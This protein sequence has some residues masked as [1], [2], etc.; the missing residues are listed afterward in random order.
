MRR[1]KNREIN[2]FSVSFLD[3]LA[4]TIGGLA[5]LLIFGVLMI[6]GI[7]SSSPPMVMTETLPD[8]YH[9]RGYLTWLAAREGMGKFFWSV[10]EGEL[11]PGLQLDEV[12]GK[13]SGVIELT[14]ADAGNP[15]P[16][17]F[18]FV[19]NCDAKSEDRVLREQ[20]RFALTV[21]RQ[22]PINSIPLRIVTEPGLP[23]AYRQKAYPLVFAAEGGQAPYAWSWS[24]QIPAGLSLTDE[25]Q[26]TGTPAA[27]GQFALNVT[28]TTP[29]GER[30]SKTVELT[31]SENYPP[32]P[33]IPPLKVLTRRIPAAVAEKDYEVQIAAHGGVPPYQWTVA[34]GQPGWLQAGAG[35]S[36][37]AGKPALADVGESSVV[38]QVTDSQNGSAR[39]DP[40]RLEV[41]PP[42][43]DQPPPLRI[44]TKALP[45]ARVGQQYSLAVAVEGGFPPYQWAAGDL[46]QESGL[47][48]S[49]GDGSLSGN[50]T[51]QGG[52]PIPISVS[53]R[54][55][56][57]TTA[58]LSLNVRPAP[59]P[60]RIL[61]A[62]VPGGR[63]GQS[64]AL[65]LSATGGYAPYEWR[66]AG[67]ELPPG[68]SLDDKTGR[69]SGTPVK[70]G[71]WNASLTVADAEQQPAAEAAAVKFEIVTE[72]G[73]RALLI[74]TRSLP[75][76]LEGAT[77]DLALACEGGAAPYNW[78]AKGD[79]PAG[80]KIEGARIIGTPE[81]EW[82]QMVKLSVAD[83]SGQTAE[84][85]F[86]LRV[87]DVMPFWLGLLLGILAAVALVVA[88]WLARI[89]RRARSQPLV[90]LS[91]TIPN[92]R[93][94]FDYSVQL[95]A[96]GG[97]PPY[98]WRVV[99]G[100][101]PKG[102]TL[103]PEGKLSGCPF[104]GV[105]VS[106]VLDLPFTV[107]LEDQK[108]SKARQR[109]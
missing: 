15:N 33:P 13:L 102:L 73:V 11:P 34:S 62:D 49:S 7:L 47:A 54:A 93:V 32:P 77:T 109:L 4:N 28:V 80:L 68:L 29:R 46:G 22:S 101:L 48:F 35:A 92:A 103:S 99:E 39:S 94:S 57:K 9:Q 86:P 24:G 27:V 10:G 1:R 36:A 105:A 91:E 37:F 25:G 38:W 72:Q 21:F 65:T 107:E 6:G 45:D 30:Q 59:L 74:A 3:V 108:G 55:G 8:G 26:I 16:R 14:A 5:F 87:R 40:I 66:V 90:I 41:L 82:D 44:K 71:T 23:P 19:V 63:A 104:E 61:T 81:Q 100:E 85:D 106:E 52:F 96:I 53:D 56:Q 17:R 98:R 58:E 79:L 78:Q 89:V 51:R 84:A 64:Y 70:A 18:E 76:L 43:E 88:L 97:A 50:P 20:R 75:T 83:A 12:T 95:A 2:I 31:V 69:I 42:T 67:G 60:V